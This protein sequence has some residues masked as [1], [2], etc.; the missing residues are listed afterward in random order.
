MSALWRE[1]GEK[2][3]SLTEVTGV[4]STATVTEVTTA[5]L[6]SDPTTVTM[7]V[8]VVVAVAAGAV[9]TAMVTVEVVGRTPRQ[10]QALET[11]AGGSR[12]S[13]AVATLGQGRMGG[14]RVSDRR[15]GRSW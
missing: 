4:W 3:G 7:L 8:T 6:V 10:L 1:T 12:A 2:G 15:Q 13:R 5:V 9:L 14:A 11:T